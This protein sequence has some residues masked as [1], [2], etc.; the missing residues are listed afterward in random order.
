MHLPQRSHLRPF[1]HFSAKNDFPSPRPNGKATLAE[2]HRSNSIINHT[3]RSVLV[4][5]LLPQ[6][7]HLSYHHF[8]IQP[9]RSF[10]FFNL[11]AFHTLYTSYPAKNS[12]PKPEIDSYLCPEYL[13]VP[14][15]HAGNNGRVQR[16]AHGRNDIHAPSLIKSPS[17][18]II[19]PPHY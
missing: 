17:V 9:F 6:C 18:P 2:T 12:F 11:Q 8:L 14:Q 1:N 4:H 10:L 19:P 13:L 5:Q 3:R 7:S 15:D 16:D